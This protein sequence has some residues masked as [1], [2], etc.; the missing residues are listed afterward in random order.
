VGVPIPGCLERVAPA[1]R[2]A[3][4][5]HGAPPEPAQPLPPPDLSG[6]AAVVHIRG[7]R[8]EPRHVS[9]KPG[10]SV[11]WVNDDNVVHTIT[12]GSGTLPSHTPLSSPFLVRG[13]S[14]R[15]T[16][17][18]EGRFEYLCLPHLDQ[19]AMRGATVTVAE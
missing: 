12:S 19:A 5:T 17:G 11:V 9:V 18:E 14:F 13:Q 1:P 4:A 6:A 3:H 15:H 16:F 10:Q 7:M 2:G 8:F